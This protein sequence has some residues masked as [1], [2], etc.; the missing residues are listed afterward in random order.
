MIIAK[1][2]NEAPK[3]EIYTPE[4]RTPK[5]NKKYTRNGIYNYIQDNEINKIN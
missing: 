3:D 1:N 2:I 5:N 4:D